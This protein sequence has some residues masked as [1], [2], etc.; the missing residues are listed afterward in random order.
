M[1]SFSFV[2]TALDGVVI[3]DT[4]SYGDSRGAFMETYQ[5]QAFAEAG[6]TATFVQDNQSSSVR[7]VVR[8]LHLQHE[9][10]QAKLVRVIAGAVFDVAV[11]V[12]PGSPTF[13]KWTGLELSAKNRRQLFIPRG[14]AHG[15]LVLSEQVTFAY[16]CDE[17]YF[18]A[19]EGGLAWD[20]PALAIAWP[21]ASG[22]TPLLSERDR[23]WPTLEAFRR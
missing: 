8:G 7:N 1:S 21:L 3:V 23:R 11:D 19:D 13:G 5:Q 14:L 4:K 20:D 22:A 12:R 18:P 17:F 9:R 15:F 10:P 16:K 6:I 2:P